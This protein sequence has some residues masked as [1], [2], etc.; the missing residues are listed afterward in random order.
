M[1]ILLV[2]LAVCGSGAL[3]L[4]AEDP[5]SAP[6][7]AI[8][9][10][11]Q[12]ALEAFAKGDLKK[13]R[14]SFEKLVEKQPDNSVFLLNLG[15]VEFRMNDLDAAERTLKDTVLFDPNAAP[16]WLTLGLIYVERNQPAEAL[17]A[18]SRTVLLEPGNARAHAYL[19]VAI[20]QRGWLFGAEQ[21]L[22]KAIEIDP[23]YADAH[24]N[25]AL[26]YLQ[27]TPPALELARRHYQR[28]LALGAAPDPLVEKQLDVP[29]EEKAP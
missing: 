5:V 16:A 28:A 25:L 2:V 1:K 17:A 9:K 26:F 12:Q 23:E 21:E 10:E 7:P 6:D 27:R 22:R 29:G 3:A 20:G 15:T 19:G 14:D 18:L 11:A 4:A 13:A 24:F 8:A